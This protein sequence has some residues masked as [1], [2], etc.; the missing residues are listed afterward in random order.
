MDWKEIERI[1]RKNYELSD[2]WILCGADASDP[3]VMKIE[4]GK[5]GVRGG[6]LKGKE[7]GFKGYIS[8]YKQ[9]II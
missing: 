7:N 2:E 8:D 5:K 1:G 4:F 6:W 9:Y 3:N